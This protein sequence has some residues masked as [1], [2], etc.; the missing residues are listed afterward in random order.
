MVSLLALKNFV[1]EKKTVTLPLLL[2]CF[3]SSKV[4]ML[5]LLDLLIQKNKVKQCQKTPSCASRCFKCSPENFVF[6]QWIEKEV[7]TIPIALEVASS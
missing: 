6:Y 4:E 5:A 3:S 1:A 2:N 7:T